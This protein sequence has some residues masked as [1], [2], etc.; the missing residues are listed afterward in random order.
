MK[1]NSVSGDIRAGHIMVRAKDNVTIRGLD[2]KLVPPVWKRL[3][4]SI[5]TGLRPVESPIL[6]SV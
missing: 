5:V 2:L 4:I 1:V 3:G 6:V